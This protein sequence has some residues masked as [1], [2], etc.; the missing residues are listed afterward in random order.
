VIPELDPDVV[1]VASRDYLTR[2][3]GV[4]YD[5]RDRPIQTSSPDEL[6][7]LMADDS[8]R[9]LAALEEVADRVVIV[10]PMPIADSDANPFDCLSESEVLEACRFVAN[11]DVLPIESIYRD[12]ADDSAVWVADFDKLACPFLPICDPV[13]NGRITR[14]D[15]Q[16]LAP[17]Y[18]V[19]L[20]DEVATYLQE[21]GIV[22]TA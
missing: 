6:A 1:V 18:A 10:E 4:I 12:L 14:F 22:H 20:A 9:S 2:R 17:A 3:P 13:V 5:D 11:Q 7:S 16:H 21:A 8:E 19:E 15:Y